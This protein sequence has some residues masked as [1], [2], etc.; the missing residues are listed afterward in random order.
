MTAPKLTV[1]NL[2]FR[3]A[4]SSYPALDGTS[5]TL[6]PNEV[7]LLLG[8]SGC[9]K[10]T[11]GLCLNGVIPRLIPGEMSGEIT[12]DGEDVY[13]LEPPERS[14][15]IG[16]VFQ[17]PESQFCTLYVQDEVAFPLENLR[18][19]PSEIR[20][21]VATSL[22]D[23]GLSD[24]ASRVVYRLSGGEKQ[25]VALASVLALDADV[26]VLDAPTAN[27]DPQ[28]TH[29]VFDTIAKLKGEKTILVVEQKV[30]DLVDILDRVM[31][32]DERG[33]IFAE[34]PPAEVFA[35]V[36]PSTL[37]A[38][39]VWY[40]QT[41]EFYYSLPPAKRPPSMPLG[42]SGAAEALIGV[43]LLASPS[44]ESGSP[45]SPDDALYPAPTPPQDDQERAAQAVEVRDLDYV[46]PDGT[47]ALRGA[48]LRIP[49]GSFFALVGQNGS[50]KT[51][52]VQHL[53]GIHRPP[54]GRV[55]LLGS[56]ISQMSIREITA[57]VGYVFQNPE[58]QFVAYNVQEELA[59]SLIRLH[60]AEESIEEKVQAMLNLFGLAE[61]SSKSPYSLSAGEM[62][63]L[64]VAT[65]LIVGPEILIL[66][67]PTFGQD[68]RNSLAI[69]RLLK[70]LHQE[71]KT[72]VMVTH[73]MRLVAEYADR[74]AVM[75]DA[76]TIL[77]GTPSELFANPDVLK[78]GSLDQPPVWRLALRLGINPG[79][80]SVGELA[81][82]VQSQQ[83]SAL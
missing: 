15:R 35:S 25:R 28:G 27:L 38:M 46:Y 14:R 70:E 47:R 36:D 40:P 50:G 7:V 31:L 68:R 37:D 9:G 60:M 54:P 24:Y 52:L 48:S 81:R 2:R 57:R 80:L 29:Q 30:D 41:T 78:K 44:V 26:L 10:T 33:H 23:V 53:I 1:R 61:L 75:A 20:T 18:V 22:E 59:Y 45:P 56:D 66:D 17:D 51:T 6:W 69:M 82:R 34:G 21:K 83:G 63:R 12:L 8:P 43:G 73:D 3:Y 16:I 71:G 67:E 64:S 58:H 19:D 65:M 11:L 42:V 72:I 32:M 79:V 76:E 55:V 49:L 13:N 62:R 74:V 5:L 39:G 4:R 77:Q